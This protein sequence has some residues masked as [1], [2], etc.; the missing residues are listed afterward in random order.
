[1]W[2][3]FFFTI[4]QFFYQYSI[5][6]L[7]NFFGK[8]QIK[9]KS[10]QSRPI[11]SLFSQINNYKENEKKRF[12]NTYEKDIYNKNMDP[13]FYN[14]KEYNKLVIQE[15]NELEKKWKIR[16]LYETTPLGNIIMF[17][18]VYKKG[19][20]Y[21]SDIH[22]TYTLLNVVAMKYVR[23]FCCR[24]LFIDDSITPS[25][26]PSPF[27]ELEKKEEKEEKKEKKEKKE[28]KEESKTIRNG[29]FIKIKKN[30]ESNKK[31]ETQKTKQE[32]HLYNVNK[33]IYMGKISN[34]SFIQKIQKKRVV[35]SN[36]NRFKDMF[37]EEHEIQKEI[38]SYSEYRKLMKK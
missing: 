9:E 6:N 3:T 1:M 27:I 15:N 4:Y 11:L 14:L 20:S 32:E 8:K 12:L 13:V 5:T 30:L 2:K 7:L 24:D 34:F 22:I 28:E 36:Q 16:L 18:D 35:L 21:Y 23:I 38:L 19:F 10:E 17:Y 31:E 25:E 33:F 26:N 29:P 37:E